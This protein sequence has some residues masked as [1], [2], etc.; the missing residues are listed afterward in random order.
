MAFAL[1]CGILGCLL[2][3]W[4][5]PNADYSNWDW[6]FEEFDISD[7]W[8]FVRVAYIHNAG[9]FGGLTGLIVAMIAIRPG[10]RVVQREKQEGM[11]G[12]EKRGTA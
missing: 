8:A 4:R 9:Y 1:C 2:G 5:G 6:A 10:E 12:P 11:E 7:K 3:L